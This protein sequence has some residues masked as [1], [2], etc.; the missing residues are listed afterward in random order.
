MTVQAEELAK[1]LEYLTGISAGKDPDVKRSLNEAARFLISRG[2]QRLSSRHSNT[3]GLE[4]RMI[5]EIF[6]NK[7][8]VKL[9]F[10]KEGTLSFAHH[11]DYG[12][13]NKWF[14]IKP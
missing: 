1:A 5:Y 6:R 10:N 14:G 4:K 8:G 3:G 7:K 13:A 11:K 9:G 2:K 12:P